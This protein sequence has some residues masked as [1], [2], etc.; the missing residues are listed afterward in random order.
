M[1]MITC[2][3]QKLLDDDKIT[4]S[5]LARKTGLSY[6]GLRKL[7]DGETAGIEFR[8]LEAICKHFKVQVNRVITYSPDP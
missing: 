7:L 5:D 6:Q 3:L 4:V 2:H 1:N 8:T